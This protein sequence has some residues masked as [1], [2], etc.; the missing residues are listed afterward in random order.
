[1]SWSQT[2]LNNSRRA[3]GAAN[4]HPL[5]ALKRF[6]PRHLFYRSLIIVVAPILL[7]QIVI[8]LVFFDRNYRITTATLTRGVANEIGYM[9]TLE[10]GAPQGAA[11]D[12]TRRNAAASFGLNAAFRPGVRLE[13]T[14]SQPADVLDRQLLYILATKIPEEASF[15]TGRNADV[16][17]VQVQLPDG[18]LVFQV[19]RGRL[20]AAD[21]RVFVLWMLG[22]SALLIG[23]ALWFLRNQVKPIER[24]ALVAESF[25]KGRN[26]PD[27]KPSGAAE[28]RRAAQA[29]IEMRER[30]ERHVRQRT[31]MLS[32]VSHD[33]RTPLTRMRLQLA[34]MPRD[35]DHD[36]MSS[37]VDEM[38][39]M[40]NEYLEFARGEGGEA[41]VETE[42][43]SLVEEAVSDSARAK[44][45]GAERITVTAADSAVIAIKRNALKRCLIN[46]IDNALRYGK[47][48][49]VALRQTPRG[50]EISVDDDGHGIAEE[51]REEAF[52]PF[53]RLDQGRNLQAGGVG[54]GL[55]IARDIARA[56]GGDVILERSPLGGLKAIVRLPG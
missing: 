37:D 35:A 47:R 39:R 30:I 54:L 24:L 22:S 55:A 49:E 18:V 11:R 31:N 13:R 7:L 45:R 10:T 21:A 6:L 17:E 32:G 2:A 50:A 16:V 20:Q 48:V 12:A 34:M 52:R 5:R 41:P 36:A 56:H 14:V 3:L 40:V 25:G 26:L 42:L 46:L 33:L 9:V 1:M 51:R 28:V 8:A 23:I 44:K 27:F 43:R 19:P 38:E 53:T 29:F 4:F 15:N